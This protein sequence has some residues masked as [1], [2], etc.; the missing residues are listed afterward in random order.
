MRIINAIKNNY[1]KYLAKGAGALALGIV[2]Y[3]SHT[4]G[5]ISS[6]AYAKTHDAKA[7]INSYNNTMFM[8]DPSITTSKAKN[9]LL[10][11]QIQDNVRHFVNSAI[12]YFKGFGSMLINSVVPLGLGLGAIVSKNNKVAGGFGIGLAAYGVIK[13]LKDVCGLGHPNYFKKN[14]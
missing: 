12:G 3:D 6:G 2:A 9:F 1:G 4:L 7:C 5:K 13:F 14:F 10:D 11:L 8:A